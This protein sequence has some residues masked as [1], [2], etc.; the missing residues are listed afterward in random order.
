M[1]AAPVVSSKQTYMLHLK[2]DFRV[3]FGNQGNNRK[4][5]KLKKQETRKSEKR[6]RYIFRKKRKHSITSEEGR[7]YGIEAVKHDSYLC[8]LSI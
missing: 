6:F 3:H 1:R 5:E 8:S 4:Q 2:S 7:G